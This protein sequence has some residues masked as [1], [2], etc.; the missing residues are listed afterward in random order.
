[1]FEK[2]WDFRRRNGYIPISTIV[3]YESR[4]Q[5]QLV[6]G[7][8]LS[9]LGGYTHLTDF[10]QD[11]IQEIKSY[12]TTEIDKYVEDK[13]KPFFDLFLKDE[14]RLNIEIQSYIDC[15]LEEPEHELYENINDTQTGRTCHVDNAPIVQQAIQNLIG[16][17]L[18]GAK[19]RC[20]SSTGCP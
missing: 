12:A 13:R 20:R 9:M 16:V 11:N 19:S 10:G 4:L 17:I 8:L 15:F 3:K 2:A 14:Q 18:D 1:D 5:R 7:D 6:D